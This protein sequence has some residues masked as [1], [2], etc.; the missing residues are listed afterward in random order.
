MKTASAEDTS[1]VRGNKRE[2][3]I[4]KTVR[5]KNNSKGE[6]NGNDTGQER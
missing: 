3:E 2:T 4:R 6:R 1:F 5:D